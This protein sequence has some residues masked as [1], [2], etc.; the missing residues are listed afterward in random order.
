MEVS[1]MQVEISKRWPLIKLVGLELEGG[2]GTDGIFPDV[3]LWHDQSV[4]PVKGYRQGYHHWGEVISPPIPPDEAAQ[5][6][7]D[8]YPT[9]VPEPKCPGTRDEQSAGFHVHLSFHSAAD[10]CKLLSRAFYTQFLVDM[11]VWGKKEC[12]DDKRFWRRLEGRNR[13]AKRR[14]IPTRQ[15]NLGVKDSNPSA[16]RRTIINYPHAL[17]GTVEV[18]LF[19]MFPDPNQGVSALEATFDS[20]Q[21]F[22]SRKSDGRDRELK[23]KLAIRDVLRKGKV[24]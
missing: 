19:P 23:M 10:Y 6:M 4:P 14:F 20:F 22:L 21:R 5:W 18:R 15:M 2:W 17:H 11:E 16:L 1:H 7:R 13:F 9:E 24:A 12:P 8:H 3:K